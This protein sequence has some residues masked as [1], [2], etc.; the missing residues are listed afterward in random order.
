MSYNPEKSSNSSS[1]LSPE[2]D[3]SSQQLDQMAIAEASELSR[4]IRDYELGFAKQLE[5]SDG[6]VKQPEFDT[7]ENLLGDQLQIIQNK[8]NFGNLTLEQEAEAKQHM[9][10]YYKEEDLCK[11]IEAQSANF[12]RERERALR[13]AILDSNSPDK[14]ADIEY[15]KGY[16]ASVIKHLDFKYMTREE[17]QDYGYETYESQRTR[18]H[19][20]TIKYLNNLNDLA[21]KYHTRPFTVRN[22]WPSDLRR[23]EEQTPAVAKIMRYDRD[24]VEEYYAI[25]FSSEVQKRAYRQQRQNRL[26]FY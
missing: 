26:G 23:K 5:R 6:Y 12:Y 4:E 2:I 19:N 10:T 20:G 3:T 15:I 25:A 11:T 18:A 16:Y 24:I 7:W 8:V 9:V 13:Q 17:V 21:R 14:T 1:D 22:F